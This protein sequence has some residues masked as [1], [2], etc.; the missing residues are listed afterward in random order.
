[1][2]FDKLAAALA[3]RPVLHHTIAAFVTCPSIRSVVVVANADRQPAI[4]AMGFGDRIRLTEGG[5]ERHFSVANGLAALPEDEVEW[6]AVHDGARPLVQVEVIERAIAGAAE[7]GAASLAHPIADTLKRAHEGKVSDS[8]SRE[9]L[10]AMET[11]QVFSRRLLAE[12]YDE[13]LARGLTVTDEVSALQELAIPVSLVEN[14]TPNLKITFPSDLIIAEAI[15]G[16][17]ASE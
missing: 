5:D 1:M 4:E 8:V 3:G 12:A 14:D 11:P 7:T 13:V 10:W 9:D 6:V 17:R 2:G 16:N 15:L